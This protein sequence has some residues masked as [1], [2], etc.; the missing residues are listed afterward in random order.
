MGNAARARIMAHV[1]FHPEPPAPGVRLAIG[2]RC[3]ASAIALIGLA[4]PRLAAAEAAEFDQ[5]AAALAETNGLAAPVGAV[6]ISAGMVQSSPPLDRLEMRI[7]ALP[8]LQIGE[9]AVGTTS[10]PDLPL[11]GVNKA[12]N[13]G[14]ADQVATALP[15]PAQAVQPQADGQTGSPQ[16][17]RAPVSSPSQYGEGAEASLPVIN[18]ASQAAPVNPRPVAAPSGAGDGLSIVTETAS[19]QPVQTQDNN[20]RVRVDTGQVEPVLAV[21]LAESERS[22][23][24]GEAATFISYSNYNAFIARGEIRVFDAGQSPDATPLAVIAADASGVA[25]WTPQAN[26][27][28]EL[29]YVYRIYDDQGRFDE[30]LP[31]ELTLLAEPFAIPQDPPARPLF[32]TRD[33]AAMRT[34]QTSRGVTVTVTGRADPAGDDVHV[35]GS[36]VPVQEDGSFVSRQIVPRDTASVPVRIRRGGAVVFAT[37]RDIDVPQN[38]WFV[39]GQGDLTFVTNDAEGPA[40]EVSG[41]GLTDGDHVTSRA[42]FYARGTIGDDWRVTASLDTGETLLEDIFSNLDRKDPRALLR[43]IDSDTHYTTYGD[44]STIVADA[45]TQGRFYLRVQRDRNSLLIG[46][47]TADFSQ[48]ELAQLNRGVFGAI[49]DHKSA[50]TTSFGEARTALTAFASDPGTIPGRDEFR[51]TG[52]SLYYLERQDITVGSERLRVEVRDRETGVVLQSHELRVNE[53]Y[54]IDYFQ[55]RISLLRP[56]SSLAADNSLIREGSGPGNIPVLVARYEYSPAVGDIAGYTL[57]GRASAWLG[58]VVQ[59][60]ATAQRETTD[61]ADQTLLAADATV[62]LHAGTYLKA[63]V[64]QTRGPGFGQANSVDGGLTFDPVAAPALIGQTALAWRS[65]LAVDFAELQGRQGDLGRISGF[66]E[67][68]EAGYS[69]NGQLSPS[70]TERW[71]INASLP[72]SDVTRVSGKLEGLSTD[73]AGE[74]LSGAVEIE[75]QLGQDFSLTAG[76]QHDRQAAGLLYNS[77]DNGRRTDAA[78]QLGYAPSRNWSLHAFGQAS[79]DHDAGRQANNRAG[80]GGQIEVSDAVSASGEVSYGDGGMGAQAQIT[81]RYGEGSEMYLG[82]ALLAD[83]TDTGLEPV[84]LL[85]SGSNGNLVLGARHRF[86]SALSIHAENRIGHGGTAPS[87]ARNFGFAYEP[88]E[89]W[90]L[91]GSFENGRIDDVSTGV[92]RRTGGTLGIGYSAP[93]FQ[94]ASN[95]EGRF[96]T[97]GGRDQDS[98]LFRNNASLSIGDDWRALARFN[99]AV[100]TGNNAS[101]RA[102]DFIEGTFG[103]AYRPVLNDRLNLLARYTYLQDLGPIGQITS[104]GETASPKQRSQVLSIDANYDLAQWFTL[105]GKFAMREGEVS[106]GRGSDQ[107]V[108]SNTQLGVVRADVR[109]VREWDAVAEVRY[110]TNDLAGNNRWGGIAA[111]YRHLGENVKAGV[112]YNFADFSDD[113][114]DQSYS[115]EGWF[116]NL[117]GKF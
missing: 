76:V 88:D 48:A 102:A 58:D 86:N 85:N 61:S 55:G 20:V 105:G 100:T 83:R 62:R 28:Q 81:R 73:A 53:D 94:I 68:F 34:I 89:H 92:F 60:G 25:R 59:L 103:M 33:E 71:A 117:V 30:T 101:L 56:L 45:P 21:G 39:V 63:E 113:L 1:K 112:G 78:V 69:A 41:D 109:F 26:T 115:S 104:G 64:A 7:E 80:V 27:A 79:L 67:N 114:G 106:L 6:A 3:S 99:Y 52:G 46:N 24:R 42:A 84:S 82:Y 23:V 75:Q 66:Y 111:I 31:Q 37:S 98:W 70:A 97:G 13:S 91:T 36:Y 96:E 87:L 90:S 32:G 43:R 11:S 19:E 29:F 51:G 65:E 50:N 40:V 4:I 14:L 10:L 49:L 5:F 22:I 95:V 9:T 12:E 47:Y 74:R 108:S 44:D 57:G 77:T 38:D 116:F 2:L 107:F 15:V 16:L 8:V 17:V 93:D 18:A 72:L 54:D 110:L 35:L